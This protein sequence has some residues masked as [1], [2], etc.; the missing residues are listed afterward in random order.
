MKNLREIFNPNKITLS[1]K[2]TIVDT[3]TGKYV[4]K[5]YDKDLE[6]LFNYLDNRSFTN[7]PKIIDKIDNNYVYEYVDENKT[8]INQ[9]ASDMSSLLAS[10]HYKTT[11]FTNIEKDN[12]K[13]IYENILD[14]ILYFENYY[15]NLFNEIE[16]EE[17]MRPSYYLLI[18]NRAK[19]SSLIGFLK[20]NIEKWYQDM[21]NNDKVRVVYNHNNLS[22]NHY[23][24]NNFISW[25]NYKIDSPILDLINVYH[26][27]F[28]KYDYETFLNK[29]LKEFSLTKEEKRLFFTVISIPKT[30]YFTDNEMDN[31]IMI[32]KFIDY[33]NNT[34]RLIRPHYP[35]D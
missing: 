31:T 25:D 10:L 18:K 9:K 2:A 20:E 16:K 33:I 26:N 28:N 1:G 13:E 7:H 23:R 4:I 29:Y 21:I 17:Y 12:I 11:Y 22:I 3:S 27:D 5:E 6:S 34:E 14:N 32:G 35:I 30:T 24:N 19:V 15:N 8:P